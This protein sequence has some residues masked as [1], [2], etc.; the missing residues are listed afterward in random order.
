MTRRLALVALFLAALGFASCQGK[1][2]DAEAPP[3][4]EPV[5]EVAEATV[6]TAP[7]PS[8]LSIE[9][10][11]AYQAA[12]LAVRGENLDEAR[13]LLKQ[14]VELQPDFTEGWYNLGATT[15]R[16]AMA[17]AVDARDQEALDLFR[18]A[19]E[20]KRRAQAL[21]DEGKWFVY[22]TREEQDQVI[23]DLRHALEDADAV[24]ADEASLLAA[25]RLWAGSGRLR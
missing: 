1:D 9:A 8:G 18:E 22:T 10:F 14:A 7:P 5:A 16:L 24:M 19:V 25:M 11:R 15:S 3:K 21:I 20:E 6:P 2:K 17:A 12:I 4:F 23:F 13:D